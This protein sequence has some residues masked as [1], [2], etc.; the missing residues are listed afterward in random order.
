MGSGGDGDRFRR[1]WSDGQ[2]LRGIRRL[3]CTDQL[4]VVSS[5]ESPGLAVLVERV[6]T[7]SSGRRPHVILDQLVEEDD[8]RLGFAG[9]IGP[10]RVFQHVSRIDFAVR[11]GLGVGSDFGRFPLVDGFLPIPPKRLQENDQGDCPDPPE[12]ATDDPSGALPGLVGVEDGSLFELRRCADPVVDKGSSDL[13]L[14]MALLP[15]L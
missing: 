2:R 5:E 1:C 10:F 8:R 12:Q 9:L 14:C 7:L 3:G 6:L 11:A 4:G 15:A 13:L